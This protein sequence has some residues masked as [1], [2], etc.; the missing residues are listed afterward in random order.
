LLADLGAEVIKV[1]AVGGEIIRHTRPRY[2]G[3]RFEYPG[4]PQFE[5]DNRGNGLSN[6]ILQTRK[7]SKVCC[8]FWM[9][10]TFF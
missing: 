5:M 9:A 10:L 7:A 6:S 1:E 8:A 4:S 2:N 3:F